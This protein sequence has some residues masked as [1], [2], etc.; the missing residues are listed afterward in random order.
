MVPDAGT[1]GA[2]ILVHFGEEKFL[3]RYHQYQGHLA[4][5]RAQYPKLASVDMRY[6]RQVVLEMQPGAAAPAGDAGAKD[7]AGEAA[8]A[9]A[10][11]ELGEGR[12]CACC[13]CCFGEGAREAERQA[14]GSCDRRSRDWGKSGREA[15]RCRAGSAAM[16]PRQENLI[17]VLDAGSSKICVLVAELQDGVLR[18]RGHGIEA[19]RGMRKGLIAELGPAAEAIN[20]AALTAEKVARAGI[21]TAVVGIG[22]THVRGVNSRGG[23]CMGSRMREITREEVRAAVDRARSVA[24]PPDR[25]VLHLLPQEFILDDQAGIHDPIG[26]VGNKLEVNLH[27]STCSGGVA[28]SVVTCANRAGLEVGDTIYEGIA[29]AEAVLS[30]D[31]RELGV[32]VADIGSSTTELAVFFEGSIAHTAVLPIGGDHFTNDLAVGLHV[33]VEEAEELKRV[34]GNCVVTAVPQVNEIEVGANLASALSAAGRP[35]GWCGNASWRR[36]WSR[37]RGSYSP[38]CATTCARAECWRHWARDAC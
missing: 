32:C 1:A 5:W 2:D 15:W 10:K 19:A 7:A 37:A 34:Y 28:Q 8:G 16:N 35:A 18:Y 20:K 33:S 13:S 17:T 27:L 4:E 29:A 38:C 22:G 31:E 21:E 9:D 6:E 36:Y 23:I 12:G 26:M 25:E 3:E 11:R 30:A 14:C 24:L